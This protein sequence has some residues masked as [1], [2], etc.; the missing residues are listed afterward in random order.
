MRFERGHGM[1]WLQRLFPR[2]T[3]SRGMT[4]EPEGRSQWEVLAEENRRTSRSA[5]DLWATLRG[6]P[7]SPVRVCPE[8]HQVPDGSTTCPYGHYVG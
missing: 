7:R 6:R 1:A 5:G 2:K 3:P 4:T 8:G